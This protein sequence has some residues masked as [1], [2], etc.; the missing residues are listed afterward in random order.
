MCRSLN[1][2]PLVYDCY[3]DK[4]KILFTQG[5]KV[6][7]RESYDMFIQSNMERIEKSIK[8]KDYAFIK[9]VNVPC[10]CC[11]E[12]LNDRARQWAY[13]I[14]VEAA[15]YKNNWFITL[16]YDDDHLPR[17]DIGAPTIRYKD[18]QLF[19]KLLRRQTKTKFRYLVGAEYGDKSN[20]PPLGRPHYHIILFGLNLPDLT[21][22]FKEAVY[23]TAVGYD[24][25]DG[26][27]KTR[28]KLDRLKNHSKPNNDH[29]LF[30]SKTIHKAWKFQGNISVGQF[31][32]DT[33]AYISQYCTKKINPDN[34]KKYEEWHCEPEVLHASTRPGIGADYFKTHPE[35]E[36]YWYDHII[37]GGHSESHVSSIPRYFDK[38]MI[39]KYGEDK[40]TELVRSR[41][42]DKKLEN[43]D[44]YIHSSS[45]YDVIH[46][47]ID[48]R[49]RKRQRLKTQL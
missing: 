37:V 2:Y 14:L 30:Y 27:Y 23:S 7:D 25:R 38:L 5:I 8:D 29:R 18:V 9:W 22:D 44:S 3:N 21:Q 12:C 46:E 6:K 19:L 35:D 16:T 33:A 39:K 34:G 15:Q 45:I 20:T 4:Q 48:Y 49:L 43:R 11:D 42:I 28:L 36:V 31:S 47:K 40:F 32:F 41:R 1:Y 17:S 10:G 13:R 26:E 24:P